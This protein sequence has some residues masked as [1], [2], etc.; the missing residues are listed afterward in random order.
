MYHGRIAQ[1]FIAADCRV[2]YAM[3]RRIKKA[4]LNR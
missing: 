2:C 3:P 1:P 4:E